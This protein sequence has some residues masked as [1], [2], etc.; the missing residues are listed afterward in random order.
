MTMQVETAP[1]RRLL[2]IREAAQVLGVSPPWL[3]EQVAR[4]LFPA[5]PLGRAVGRGRVWRVR[6]DDIEA[7]ID[8]RQRERTP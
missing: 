5:V 8:Q 2:T 6:P 7:F 4:G 1:S 3:Y